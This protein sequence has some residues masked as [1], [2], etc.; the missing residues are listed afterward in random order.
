MG[1]S[2]SII[3][4]SIFKKFLSNPKKENKNKYGKIRIL[5][6]NNLISGKLENI[7]KEILDLNSGKLIFPYNFVNS[8]NLFYVGKFIEIKISNPNYLQ[9][10]KQIKTIKL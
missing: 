8:D 7:S 6:S 4:L 9:G 1:N 10:E 5:D 3:E 2:S